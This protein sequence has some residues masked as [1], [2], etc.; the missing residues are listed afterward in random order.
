MA[1][2]TLVAVWEAIAAAQPERPALIQGERTVSWGAFDAR[3]DALAAHLIGK[4]LGRQA[5]VAAY[6]FNG[7][8]YLETYFAAFKGGFAP[9]NTNYRY[10]PEELLYL[11]DNADAE[12]IVFHAGFAGT[13][14]A[15]RDRLPRVKA[16]VAVAEPGHAVPAWAEDY[17]A[18]AGRT[19]AER[20]AQ[21]PW[22]RSGDDLLL[23]Y[24]GGT[25]GMPKGVMWRQDDLFNVIGAG[26]HAA[27]GV[28][29]VTSLEEVAARLE[30][31]GHV[32]PTALIACPL[33]HGTGQFSAFIT[34]NL[35]G[36]VATL[37]SRKFDAAELWNEAERLKADSIAIVGLAFS[38]PML[39]ALEAHPG[40][41]D[42][43]SVKLMSSSG[44]MWSQ[45]NKRGLLRHAT[46][47]VIYDSL[48]SSEAVGLGASASAPGQE[49][50]T[51]AFMLGPNCAVFTE[52]GRRVEPGSGER[53]MVA[54]S[55]FLPTGYYKDPEK[56][57]K[58]FRTFEGQRWSVPGDWAEVNPDGTLKL[59][60]RGSV[61]INT[62]G[63]KVFPEEVEEALKTHPAVRDAV[64]VG[65]PDP[66]FG[67]RI[68]A[69]VEPE[70]NTEPTLAD[71]SQHVHGRLAGYKAP[72]ELVLVESIGRAPNG[73]VDYKAVKERA[74]AELGT[75]A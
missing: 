15:I 65:V 71:L 42:L 35:G 33:M 7:P 1:G 4:G 31:P 23:L 68:C 49:A 12:A 18:I 34:L 19:P 48:G 56:S 75:P 11:F 44:S 6:L 10:G 58:T 41:W 28:E 72:R 32:R 36:T 47:A 27:M 46:N 69:V 62:G 26:G 9:V 29:P 3:A 64:V 40:R 74:L 8:E 73:K 38:T 17:E 51:A 20:P 30:S 63:E 52:D 37:P 60:G 57:A 2:W 61:C 59:L 14:E 21:A 67:E 39:E 22:G 16:W 70:A 5:K 25:T 54:V 53:G 13:L 43:S 66:R 24:T 45:E 55:G 50:A